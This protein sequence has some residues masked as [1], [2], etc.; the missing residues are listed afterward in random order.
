MATTN[1]Q[2]FGRLQDP[3]I[4][5]DDSVKPGDRGLG[6]NGLHSAIKHNVVSISSI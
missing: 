4:N 1:K 2:Y 5:H 6:P 3:I